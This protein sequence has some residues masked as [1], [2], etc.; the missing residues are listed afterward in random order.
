MPLH[1]I[2]FSFT[3]INF[4]L[5][6]VANVLTMTEYTDEACTTGATASTKPLMTC[7]TSDGSY[8]GG[9]ETYMQFSCGTAGAGF[10]NSVVGSKGAT[11]T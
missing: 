9:V 10:V 7:E 8:Y 3:T 1:L 5:L 6:Y 11:L 4:I 2:H